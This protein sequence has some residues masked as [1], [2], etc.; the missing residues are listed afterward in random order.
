MNQ[1]DL[2][3]AQEGLLIVLSGPSGTGKG[4]LV[5]EIS[6]KDKNIKLS[7]SVT[8]RKPRKGEVDGE[9]YFFVPE[10]EFIR[11]R[12][13]NELIEWVEYCGNHYGTP[14]KFIFDTIK[15][16]YDIILDIEVEGARNFKNIFPQ[17][18]MIFVIPPSMEELRKRMLKRGTENIDMI[19]ARLKR[20]EEEY[21]YI[22]NYEYL[23]VNDKLDDAVENISNIIKAEK[24]SIKRMKKLPDKTGTGGSL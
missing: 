5:K 2:R 1:S 12:D 16:G 4:T 3:K 18:V 23:V 21:N 11:M 14:K 10:P 6:Q 13:N 15:K 7:V 24:F 9:S 17:S 20:S 19:E 8:T 22:N